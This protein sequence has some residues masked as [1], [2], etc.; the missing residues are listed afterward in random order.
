MSSIA[1]W[2]YKN[3]AVVVPFVSLDL[4]TGV[5]VY[6]APY[7]IACTW[8]AEARQM[9][10]MDGAEFVSSHIVF[11]EDERPKFLDRIALAF[12]LPEGGFDAGSFSVEDFDLNA[13]ALDWG[14]VAEEI[15]AKTQYD[16]MMFAD[17]PDYKL[18]TT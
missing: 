5:T 14:G 10:S 3:T 12:D 15:R 8:I 16:M 18:V 9:R 6:G 2:S 13:F 7:P 11:T 4:V 17:V 1:R